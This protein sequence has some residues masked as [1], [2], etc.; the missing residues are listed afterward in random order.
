MH[1][2]ELLALFQGIFKH[3]NADQSGSINSYEMRNAVNDAGD[4]SHRKI[5]IL[6]VH[7]HYKKMFSPTKNI[8]ADI[9]FWGFF[10]QVLRYLCLIFPLLF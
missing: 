1:Q 9:L 4:T 8:H 3:Y 2:T 7:P 10:A 5:E 6:S